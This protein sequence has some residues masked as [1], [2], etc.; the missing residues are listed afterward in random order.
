MEG[1]RTL[2]CTDCGNGFIWSVGEQQFYAGKG[3]Q[4]PKRCKK[5][6]KERKVWKKEVEK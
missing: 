4:E 1:D 2:S 3:F 6:R 5:C